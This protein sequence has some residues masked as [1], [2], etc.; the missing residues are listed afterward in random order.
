MNHTTVIIDKRDRRFRSLGNL[1]VEIQSDAGEDVDIGSMQWKR[2]STKPNRAFSPIHAEPRFN[3]LSTC[4]LLSS[5]EVFTYLERTFFYC[6][7]VVYVISLSSFKTLLRYVTVDIITC[8]VKPTL[9][10]PTFPRMSE[11][12]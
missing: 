7:L 3:V 12:S 10:G 6:L 11:C 4:F 9:V 5:P 1:P 2:C 8:A